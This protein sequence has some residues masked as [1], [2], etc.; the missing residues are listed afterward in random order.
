M[1]GQDDVKATSPVASSLPRGP[2]VTVYSVSCRNTLPL[3][4]SN[5]ATHLLKI[6]PRLFLPLRSVQAPLCGGRSPEI[7]L[8]LS[9]RAKLPPPIKPCTHHP[10]PPVAPHAR[11]VHVMFSATFIRATPGALPTFLTWQTPSHSARSRPGIT[12]SWKPPRSHPPSC[13]HVSHGRLGVP[14]AEH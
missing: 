12:C 13:P 4:K 14:S 10:K 3:G 1:Q 6:P 9:V 11:L 5:H 7:P 8:C 2:P